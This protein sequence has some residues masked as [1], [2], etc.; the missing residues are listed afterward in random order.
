MALAVHD[1]LSHSL[2]TPRYHGAILRSGIKAYVKHL[3][4]C[5][6]HEYGLGIVELDVTWIA[7]TLWLLGSQ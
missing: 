2:W 7:F 3:F 1:S 6:M 5:T 4:K